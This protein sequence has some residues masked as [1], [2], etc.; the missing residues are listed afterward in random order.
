MPWWVQ[1]GVRALAVLVSL[2]G[3]WGELH[4]AEGDRSSRPGAVAR[5]GP[6]ASAPTTGRQIEADLRERKRGVVLREILVP[7]SEIEPGW[8][9]WMKTRNPSC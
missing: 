6:M 8:V 7:H 3:G 9:A 4:W 1:T 5:Q 2:G